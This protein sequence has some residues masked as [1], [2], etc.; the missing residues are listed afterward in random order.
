MS[1]ALLSI[2]STR[3]ASRYA[4]CRSE[5]MATTAAVSPSTAST[6]AFARSTNSWFIEAGRVKRRM[7]MRSAAPAERLLILS[8]E[9]TRRERSARFIGNTPPMDRRSRMASFVSSAALSRASS[10]RAEASSSSY[11]SEAKRSTT[12]S[13][14]LMM[15]TTSSVNPA[16]RSRVCSSRS[17]PMAPIAPSRVVSPPMACRM[18]LNLFFA[19]AAS[20][21]NEL[22]DVV[23]DRRDDRAERKRHHP[24][25]HDS[26][27]D[28][29]AYRTKSAA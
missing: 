16:M 24:G 14:L 5:P 7:T 19:I 2:L 26:T 28:F 8:I 22:Q 15:T 4:S 11:W 10:S 12:S 21:E 9:V 29:P 23:G 27:E 3:P 6:S 18:D 13:S 25:Q 1:S 17:L 20:L